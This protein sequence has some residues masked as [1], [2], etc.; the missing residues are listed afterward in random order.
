MPERRFPEAFLEI[1]KDEDHSYMSLKT[2]RLPDG[3]LQID[4]EGWGISEHGIIPTFSPKEI[5]KVGFVGR[6]GS[7]FSETWE[8]GIF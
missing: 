8:E 1:G 6:C 4:Y 2:T 5:V 3:R 7:V